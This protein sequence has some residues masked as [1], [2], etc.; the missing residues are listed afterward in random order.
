MVGTLSAGLLLAAFFAIY[1]ISISPALSFPAS[2][3]GS[4]NESSVLI[5]DVAASGTCFTVTGNDLALDCQFHRITGDGTGSGIALSNNFNVMVK[6]CIIQGF[7]AGVNAGNSFA[8]V[9]SSLIEGNG[10][11][12]FADGTSLV[13]AN[14]NS[15]SNNTLN[16]VNQNPNYTSDATN[17]WWGT[18]N[19][20]AISAAISGSIFFQPFLSQDPYIDTDNDGI[21]LLFDNCPLTS[22]PGQE[23]ADGDGVGDACDNC[24]QDFNP[25]QENADSDQQGDACDIDDDN[26]FVCDFGPSTIVQ[27]PANLALNA[28]ATASSFVPPFSPS[29]AVDGDPATFLAIVGIP[30]QSLTIDLGSV[31]RIDRAR[32]LFNDTLSILFDYDLQVSTDNVNYTAVASVAGNEVESNELP[33]APVDARYV[34][35][36]MLDFNFEDDDLRI[37][38]LEVY[39]STTLCTG[40]QSGRDVCPLVSNPGQ[41]DGDGDAVGDV[42]DNCV[43]VSNFDQT[44]LD[45]DGKGDACDVNLF[46]NSF[47][48]D[49]VNENVTIDPALLTSVETGYYVIQLYDPGRRDDVSSAL[50]GTIIGIIPQGAYIIQTTRTMTEIQGNPDV[51]WAEIWQPAFKFSP[52]LYTYIGTLSN[53]IS[54]FTVKYF[55][56]SRDA[57]NQSLEALGA[58]LVYEFDNSMTISLAEL[59]IINISFIPEVFLVAPFAEPV[60]KNDVARGITGVQAIHAGSL[61]MGFMGAGELI[62]ILDS[63][64][65][66]GTSCIGV[67]NCTALNPTIHD[68]F[69][70]RIMEIRRTMGAGNAVDGSGHGTHV[71]G[72]AVGDGSRSGGQYAGAAPAAN[73]MM[74]QRNGNEAGGI[75]YAISQGYRIHSNSWGGVEC[76]FR[77][78]AQ[79]QNFDNLSYNNLGSAIVF[80]AGNEDTPAPPMGC[81]TGVPP[82][83]NS[84]QPESIAKNV[85]AVGATEDLRTAFGAG[86]DDPE[87][88]AAFSS[89]GPPSSPITANTVRIKPDVVAPGAQIL[90]TNVNL[91]LLAAAANV[92]TSGWGVFNGNYTYCGGTSMATPHVSGSLAIISEYLKKVKSYAGS[93]TGALLKA[94][95]INGAED[96]GNR[97]TA[98]HGTTTSAPDNDQGWG[99]LNMNDTLFPNKRF[100]SLLYKDDESPARL[101][102]TGNRVEY[103]SFNNVPIRLSEDVN[104]TVTLVW[105]DQAPTALTHA[106]IN[107]LDLIL[108]TSSEEYRGNIFNAQGFSEKRGVRV[109]QKDAVN[110]VEKIHVQAPEDGFYNITVRAASITGNPQAF[111][112][113]ASPVLGI[114][115]AN[116]TNVTYYFP[117]GAKIYAQAVGLDNNTVVE[118]VTVSH[119]NGFSWNTSVQVTSGATGVNGFKFMNKKPTTTSPDGTIP[120][121]VEVWDTSTKKEKDI[122]DSNGTFNMFVNYDTAGANVVFTKGT[123]VIDYHKKVGFRVGVINSSTSLGASFRDRFLVGQKVHAKGVGF[124]P[125]TQMDIYVIKDQ[126]WTGV[127]DGSALPVPVVPK[128]TL[129]S[130]TDGLI[131]PTVWDAPNASQRGLYDIVVDVNKNGKYDKS[132]DVIDGFKGYGFKVVCKS[133]SKACGAV[134]SATPA[135][136]Q[137]NVF[138][139]NDPAAGKMDLFAEADTP[140]DAYLV[141]SASPVEDLDGATLA[142]VSGGKE[143][144]M[145]QADQALNTVQTLWA[146]GVEGDYEIIIDVNQDGKFNI[147]EDIYDPDGLIVTKDIST[148]RFAVDGKGNLH[149]VAVE[150]G[151]DSTTGFQFSR[152][153]YGKVPAD[154]GA[155]VDIGNPDTFDWSG[156]QGVTSFK[157]IYQTGSRGRLT[158][159]DIAVDSK[160]EPH[161]IFA[162][163]TSGFNW[164][165]YIKLDENGNRDRCMDES[166]PGACDGNGLE[167]LTYHWDDFEDIRLN[168]P[169]IAMDQTTDQPV[170]SANVRFVYPD[171]FYYNFIYPSCFIGITQVPVLIHPLVPFF[172]TLTLKAAPI[173]FFGDS[174]QVGMRVPGASGAVQWPFGGGTYDDAL[175]K[176]LVAANEVSACLE[177]IATVRPRGDE[178]WVW[179]T[180]DEGHT[181]AANFDVSKVDVDNGSNIHVAYRGNLIQGD[182]SSEKRVRYS[183]IYQASHVSDMVISDGPM[184]FWF[185]WIDIDHEDKFHIAWQA[186]DKIYYYPELTGTQ[187]EVGTVS[188][189]AA[190]ARPSLSVDAE[191]NP[192]FAWSDLDNGG[193]ILQYRKG[194][195]DGGTVSFNDPALLLANASSAA[196]AAAILRFPLVDTNKLA[197]GSD[198]EDKVFVG[199]LETTDET[200]IKFRRTTPHVNFLIVLDGIDKG[201]LD[202]NIGSMP[203]LQMLLNDFPSIVA[204][205][206]PSFPVTTMSTQAE[207]FTGV[208]AAV[209][210]VLGDNFEAGTDYLFV[211]DNSP[212]TSTVNSI[213]SGNGAQTLFDYLETAGRSKASAPA[214]ITQGIQASRP[215]SK[216]DAVVEFTLGQVTNEPDRATY[217]ADLKNNDPDPN[218]DAAGLIVAYIL[219]HD[220]GVATDPSGISPATIDGKI[221]D[222]MD[223]LKATGMFNDTIFMITSEHGF[224]DTVSDDA[225]SLSNDDLTNLTNPAGVNINDLYLNGRFAYSKDGQDVAKVIANNSYNSPGS[226]WFG[227]VDRIL[228]LSGG[229][230]NDYSFDGTSETLTP[231]TD[232]FLS[233]FMG[234]GSNPSMIL[235]AAQDY[236]FGEPHEAITEESPLPFIIGGKGFELFSR[237]TASLPSALA[238]TD[239]TPTVGFFTGGQKAVD[240]MSSSVDGENFYDPQLL[241]V[242]GSPVDFHLYDSQGR[243]VGPDAFGN[244]ELEIPS[245]QYRI[246][247]ITGKKMISLLQAPDQ[248]RFE[249]SSFGYGMFSLSV[250]MD[251]GRESFAVEYPKTAITPFS[252]GR[253]DLDG[254]F[255]LEVDYEGDG[256]FETIVGPPVMIEVL[257]DMEGMSATADIVRLKAKTPASTDLAGATGVT[258]ELMN[259]MELANERISVRKYLDANLDSAGFYTLDSFVEINVTPGI[260]DNSKLLDAII[261]YPEQIAVAKAL[262]EKSFAIYDLDTLARLNSTVDPVN[263]RIR[264]SLPGSGRYVVAT[265][266]RTPRIE[267]IAITPPASNIPNATVNVTAMVTDD[268]A[269]TEVNATLNGATQGMAFNSA[270]GLYG[271]LIA[272]PGISGRYDVIVTAADNTGNVKSRISSYLLDL[273]P[274]RI[275]IQSPKNTSH[276]TNRITLGFFANEQAAQAYSVDG[277]PQ[278][279]VNNTQ[280]FRLTSVPLTLASGQHSIT[281]TATDVFGNP[282]SKTVDFSIDAESIR[283]S[284]F[285]MALFDRPNTPVQ[286]AAKVTNTLITPVSGV[287]VQLFVNG[288]LSGSQVLNLTGEESRDILFTFS[289]PAGRYNVSVMAVPLP[290]ESYLADNVLH[291]EILITSKV[292]LLL[293]N[294]NPGSDDA[295]YRQAIQ[296]AGG[297]G[298]DYIPFDVSKRGPPGAAL[299]D[300]FPLVVWLTG[301]DI[302][303]TPIETRNIRSFMDNRGYLL[304]FS[305]NLGSKIGSDSFYS[306]Y[307]L[308]DFRKA[309][310]SLTVEGS[311]RDP[312]GNGFLFTITGPGEEIKPLAPGTESFR[313]SGG[314]SA[315][316]KGGN[317]IFKSAY[318]TFGLEDVSDPAVRTQVMER[319]LEFFDI[320]IDPPAL[321]GISPP[322]GFS[323]PVNTSSAALSLQTGETAECR[324]SG[325]TSFFGN[326]SAFNST[327]STAHTATVGGLD[328][329]KNFTLM[330]NCKDVFGNENDTEE[331]RF[332]IH[333]RTFLPPAL[334]AITDVVVHE[335]DA[336]NITLNLTDPENDPL[337]IMAADIELFGLRP[338][339]SRFTIAGNSLQL[340]P[341]YNDAGL[342]KIRVS[343][344]DG[345][346]TVSSDFIMVIIN[347]NR[348]PVL[349]AIGSKVVAEDAFF[350]LDADA[351]DPDG[352]NIEFSDNSSLFNINPSTGLITFTPKHADVGT[353]SVNISVN[354]S[355]LADSEV[356][357][358]RVTNTND[359]P[360]V[361]FIPPQTAVEGTL[362]TYQV[363]ASD[364][365][366]DP[367]AFSASTQLFNITPQGLINFTPLN[368][369]VGTHFIN[370]TAT[371]GLASDTELLNLIVHEF[372]QAPVI[373]SIQRN[374]TVLVNETL[375]I[376]VTACDPD[377]DPG[378]P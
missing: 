83:Q 239:I 370:I 201:F 173:T 123:D 100:T 204:E 169:T 144:I 348:P 174:I 22:N 277:G 108:N 74:Q 189:P 41:E 300:R 281:A 149:V 80:A 6:N 255:S 323:F 20:A 310:K 14:F 92:C 77:Y 106:L 209:H 267:S 142:D 76:M 240:V 322:A 91:A 62:D 367:L 46:L 183:K 270:T 236:Y 82:R 37:N 25:F 140:V 279:P 16:F 116:I 60:N 24:V 355:T 362:F 306:D 283:V 232:A 337:N 328:N 259:K 312:I 150:N 303:L 59:N 357:Q 105:A 95:I 230:Y 147:S 5:S 378:C 228:F 333:N 113:V 45:G 184:S 217:L 66:N 210:G 295:V 99:R 226:E 129:T 33:F 361:Q 139:E 338:I 110:N 352:D 373:T 115:A 87:D 289:R 27:E 167:L 377:F 330:V 376:N 280:A 103:K 336:V 275:T 101:S 298:Y 292:P 264:A 243:H 143:T 185:P 52:D 111:A 71:A 222:I 158:F 73:F 202:N 21:I 93:P 223:S 136:V 208:K 132:M 341:N 278:V 9:E 36:Q 250:M 244:I 128:V 39:G 81:N 351:I 296:A 212:D 23:D 186:G 88:I 10:A 309:G 31:R 366:G 65:D 233:D 308:A 224:T 90:S 97:G 214:I 266:D 131:I 293:V 155:K 261:S 127:A 327:N 55:S 220:H 253:L 53:N 170:I 343:A 130:N 26:D 163:S 260:L 51:R 291:D 247:P 326:M 152:V 272:G 321:S 17:N 161:I 154:Y 231:A 181:L 307:L 190:T 171:T 182:F 38:E 225:H 15:I 299:M 177:D 2:S 19:P 359:R 75:S 219:T 78:L 148:P 188:D 235:F 168:F 302:T 194:K 347:V 1:I 32:I 193:G 329:G 151:V 48:F 120:P 72:T 285:G 218:N 176:Y 104:A 34:R 248:Y 316:V 89:R 234:P 284:D 117:Y 13:N 350:Q 146:A 242:G 319:T 245:S 313:Y 141:A 159:P 64:L 207:I 44:D 126:D 180:V 197:A 50:N 304:L 206:S 178:N 287:N 94:M 371:D 137:N 162:L 305:N 374:I 172:T 107:D 335:N 157:N 166:S 249:V 198:W 12:I 334:G 265:T 360:D 344:S 112:V 358:L 297:L 205:A 221:G 369:D 331:F 164:L 28:A 70:G 160:G 311:F 85:I 196:G 254:A 274:P 57:V 271:A 119:K 372:N 49:P 314:E 365:D 118:V 121:G 84:I 282:S 8:A 364:T 192:H 43:N 227:K 238:A 213:L 153:I 203:N 47:T 11:G 241:I 29:L 332:H 58:Q 61:G 257:Q 179:I 114:D 342:Y 30:P 324:L 63:G 340:Q 368:A 301:G 276:I 134:A 356:V 345:F 175:R 263:N 353:Y 318:Y 191:G 199:W 346:D 375:N 98:A 124:P 68:D 125:S 262:S 294:D 320:D 122:F 363:L 195:R 18:A 86:S 290:Q 339:A 3:C 211:P 256:V 7:S 246:D 54:L 145:L 56:G 138:A 42:C 325:T 229:V 349:A 288:S 237:G 4:I 286:A 216:S 317:G 109:G 215:D 69:K 102:A 200:I 252:S 187:T 354:D 67:A 40:G 35:I 79:A 96:M 268:S 135:G 269:I 258:V 251:N 133:G 273:D 315:A 156:V 165:I